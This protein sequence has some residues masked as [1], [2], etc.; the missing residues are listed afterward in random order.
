[1]EGIINK[2]DKDSVEL[3]VGFGTVTIRKEDV[4]SI[5]TSAALERAALAQKWDKKA[6]QLK[7]DESDLAQAREKRFSEYAQWTQGMSKNN[8]KSSDDIKE[9]PI[10]H[11]PDSKSILTETIL[12]NTVKATLV[13]D[14]GAS[15]IV[16]SKRKGEE[17][18]I[19]LVTDDKRDVMELQ[20]TGGRRVNAK[21][22]VLKSV[23][24]EQVEEK[25]VLA[26]IL[27]E[28]A[29]D[30]GFKD[31]LLGR[32][33]LNRFSIKIDLKNMKMVLEKLR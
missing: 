7:K 15:L 20:L 9:V 25:D 31:G 8:L 21:A 5:S 2:E 33:F 16:L 27:L 28:D 4:K 22:V 24:L 6:M 19:D 29:V 32:T 12:N 18:G 11:E 30:I 26:A 3:D 13:L 1:M 17:L 23:R 10:M 14:T